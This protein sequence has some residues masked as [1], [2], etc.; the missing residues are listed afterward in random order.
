MITSMRSEKHNVVAIR[1]LNDTD[2]LFNI[3]SKHD[4]NEWKAIVKLPG[5]PEED[6]KVKKICFKFFQYYY[7]PVND[8][9]NGILPNFYY[10]DQSRRQQ[11]PYISRR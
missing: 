11:P 7:S 9:N 2:C 8:N 4:E 1:T 6:V 5:V 3:H 10:L